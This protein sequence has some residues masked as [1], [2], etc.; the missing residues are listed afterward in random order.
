MKTLLIDNYDSYTHILGHMVWQV[1]GT[2]PIIVRNDAVTIDALRD[3]QVDAI[4]ISPGPGR[5]ERTADF[6]VCDAIIDAFPSLPILG[7]C[8]GHQGL[9]AHFGARVVRAPN[10]MHG[11]SSRILHDGSSL[12][13]G[14]P[15]GFRAVRYHSLVLSDEHL[16]AAVHVTAR[17]DDDGSIMAITIEGR[18]FYGV[19]FHPE[20]IGTE[21][22]KAVAGR[23]RDC[24]APFY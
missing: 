11:K 18:P 16:P 15:S 20:S 13:R 23:F 5:P 1:T 21:H 17:A 4:V 8:L 2:K 3:A 24:A 12:F 22:G 14:I 6:G 7:V 9:G 19:Q 10:V